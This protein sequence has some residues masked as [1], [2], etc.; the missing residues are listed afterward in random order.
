ME[1]ASSAGLRNLL[2]AESE[3]QVGKLNYTYGARARDPSEWAAVHEEL[4]NGAITAK[5]SAT[6]LGQLLLS[7]VDKYY[8]SGR[9]GIGNPTE[10]PS[11]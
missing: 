5:S 7:N 9:Q 3:G 8:P 10:E 2:D 1:W 11:G 6:G 4:R